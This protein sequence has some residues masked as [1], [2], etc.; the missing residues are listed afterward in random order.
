MVFLLLADLP[1]EFIILALCYFWFHAALLSPCWVYILSYHYHFSCSRCLSCSFHSLFMAP[2]FIVILVPRKLTIT[3]TIL[4]NIF[5]I[6]VGGTIDIIEPKSSTTVF[7]ACSLWGAAELVFSK[8]L[9]VTRQN[10][11]CDS[12]DKIWKVCEYVIILRA[13]AIPA[14]GKIWKVCEDVIL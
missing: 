8:W 5:L 2:D 7:P 10:H 14:H 13:T 6:S 12:H 9:H 3:I 11:A 1:L 4:F